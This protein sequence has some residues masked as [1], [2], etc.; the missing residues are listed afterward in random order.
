[1]KDQ[2]SAELYTIIT[3]DPEFK[4]VPPAGFLDIIALEKNARLIITD[5]GGLQKEAFFFEK[6]CVI[7]RPQTEWI[8][9]VENGNAVLADAS[10][11]KILA[12][13]DLLMNKTDLSYPPLYGDGHAAKFICE[14]IIE[15]L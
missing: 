5:S 12:G 8:E 6:P 14:R 10:K 3:N 11:E 7:L 9:I 2:L 15:D 13:F 4:I 1:M